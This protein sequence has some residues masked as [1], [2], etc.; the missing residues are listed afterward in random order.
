MPLNIIEAMLC[1]RPVIASHNRGHDELIEDGKTG[2]L[3]DALDAKELA[4][5]IFNLYIH[6]DLAERF[7]ENAFSKAQK[8]TVNSVV[9]Q[10]L[11]IIDSII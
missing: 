11:A 7:G 6:P 8:Y 4:D 9:K 2:F 1:K 3:I 10:M 5:R